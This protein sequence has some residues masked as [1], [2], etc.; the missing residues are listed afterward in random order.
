M[1]DTR[2]W[3]FKEKPHLIKVIIQYLVS[4][5]TYFPFWHYIGLYIKNKSIK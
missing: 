2:Y 5:I 3:I 1:L 4:G